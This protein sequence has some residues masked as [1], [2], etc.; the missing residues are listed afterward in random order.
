M[1]ITPNPTS[2]STA[3]HYTWG[4]DCDGWRLVDRHDLSI[5]HER[6]PA[7]RREARHS[8]ARSRQYFFVLHG[9]LS[10]EVEGATHVLGPNDGLEI[11]PGTAHQAI[12]AGAE[13]VEFLVIS[14]PTTQGD[15]DPA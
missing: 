9:A 1:T 5:I 6:M 11:A 8:H 7:G 13:P 15:R 4:G 3:P 10:L 2:K 14:H 12:N